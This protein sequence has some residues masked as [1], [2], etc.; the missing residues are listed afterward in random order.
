MIKVSIITSIPAP[1][2]IDFFSHL[3]KE[4]KDRYEFF[5]IFSSDSKNRDWKNDFSELK[6][7]TLLN[8]RM[9][10]R[11][12]KLD[13]KIFIISSGLWKKLNEI[14]PDVVIGMEYNPTALEALV[15][16]KVYRKKYISW[17]D[18]TLYSE[19]NI[20]R[21]QRLIR[22]FVVK[23]A[24]SYIASSSKAKEAQIAYGADAKKI[25]ISY[26][27]FDIKR[28][29]LKHLGQ[30][31]NRII[32]VGSL[33]K[34]KGLDL[35]INALSYVDQ[36]FSLAVVGDGIERDEYEKLV[37]EKKIDK[38][39]HFYGFKNQKE[40]FEIYKSNDI[41][42]IP[43]RE[44]CYGLVVLEAMAAGLPIISSKYVDSCYDLV[45]NGKNGF[46]VDPENTDEFVQRI[47]ELLKSNKKK[48][49]FGKASLNKIDSFTF[50][51]TAIQFVAAV[52]YVMEI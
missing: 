48:M 37:N 27:S 20:G 42:V 31:E 3:Q 9:F 34:R 5:V 32:F 18:G 36:P 26:L 47:N 6:N 17:T 2:R 29:G 52:D 51:N 15:W 45:E 23:N 7:F 35:L 22:K 46:I 44:D 39:V 50:S 28:S 21:I 11:K 49:E 33:I 13:N 4:Y 30:Y 19:R 38:S 16:S 8:S 43:S 41:F 40:V 25:F 14:N 12:K 24:H 1:Y 10:K